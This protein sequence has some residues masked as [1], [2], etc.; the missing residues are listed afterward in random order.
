MECMEY[1]VMVCAVSKEGLEIGAGYVLE[2]TSKELAIEK[3]LD[4]LIRSIRKGGKVSGSVEEGF[5]F[6]DP[7]YEMADCT[8]IIKRE[9]KKRWRLSRQ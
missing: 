5:K 6:E 3:V 7:D 4:Y 8:I 9:M 2:Y 1:S